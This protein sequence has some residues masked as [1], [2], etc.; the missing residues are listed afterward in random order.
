MRYTYNSYDNRGR[1]YDTTTNVDDLP[2]YWHID[3]YVGICDNLHPEN[4]DILI[5]TSEQMDEWRTKL[6]RDA[7]WAPHIKVS[8]DYG[9]AKVNYRNE[10]N[11]AFGEKKD[12][13]PFDVYD[14]FM[15][16]KRDDSRTEDTKPGKLEFVASNHSGKSLF[17]NIPQNPKNIE[18]AKKPPLA[19]VPPI[20]FFALGLAM[21]DG[22][23][24]YGKFNWRGSEVTASI[25]YRAM[26]S[27]LLHWYSG[28]DHATDSKAH[29]LGHLMAGASI[30]LDAELSGVFIDDRPKVDPEFNI[31]KLMEILKGK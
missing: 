26:L 20:A 15:S 3:G 12:W 5:R 19:A 9:P 22:A 18:G 1:R 17:G 6:E 27:H 25:F 29:H 24:K 30:I 11:P 8:A 23:N 4:T 21:Q 10:G 31:D 14:A 13:D 7:A 16:N 28:E 2:S